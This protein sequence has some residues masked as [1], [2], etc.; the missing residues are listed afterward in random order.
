M[1]N[2]L[3][4][5]FIGAG[6]ALVGS[7]IGASLTYLFTIK[8]FRKEQHE[9]L[10]AEYFKKVMESCRKFSALLGPASENEKLENRIVIRQN[11]KSYINELA[12]RNFFETIHDFV[13]SEEGSHLPKDFRQKVIPETRD[14]FM[15][16]IE[17]SQAEPNGWISI[18]SSQAKKAQNAL[19]WMRHRASI[20][21]G[22]NDVKI[23]TN[24][25]DLN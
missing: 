14:F 15:K 19:H 25:L 12:A 11:N 22:L 17:N 21:G 20:D 24:D 1:D 10:R 16:I 3:I 13:Y 23:P 8:Q 18:T 7:V 6:G 9:I 5:A 2:E 4:A